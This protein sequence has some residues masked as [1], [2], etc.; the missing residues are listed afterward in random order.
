MPYRWTAG[1]VPDFGKAVKTNSPRHMTRS[2]RPNTRTVHVHLTPQELEGHTVVTE[3]YDH[4]HK[5]HNSYLKLATPVSSN[6]VVLPCNDPRIEWRYDD[7][8]CRQ[9]AR[10]YI[11][12]PPGTTSYAKRCV[13]PETGAV[14]MVTPVP[15]EMVLSAPHGPS[16]DIIARWNR[17][18]LLNIHKESN[19]IRRLLQ[20][21]GHICCYIK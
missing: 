17:C 19:R 10:A 21:G 4:V 7:H 14:I 20:R 2:P 15:E 13:R 3:W 11:T 8:S 6:T 16:G 5:S 18:S 1:D 9:S 12:A